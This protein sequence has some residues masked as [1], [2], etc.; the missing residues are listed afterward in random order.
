MKIIFYSHTGKV[1]GAENI[2]LLLLKR[3][4]R[5][6][7]SP[8]MI[9]PATGDLAE[10]VPKLDIPVV[11]VDELT[12]RF[13]W[14]IDRL[15]KY[16]TSFYL[17][18]RQLRSE[19]INEDA[20]V[21]HA[22]SVRAGLAIWAASLFTGKKVFWHLQDELPKHPF[23]TAIRLLVAS[24]SRIRLIAVS[25]AT[26]ESFR[27][28]LLHYIGKNVPLKV[29]NNAIEIEKFKIDPKNRSNVREELN[30][31]ENEFV[32]GIIGQITPRKGQLE[33]IETFAENQKNLPDSTLLIVGAPMF[34]QDHDYLEKIKRTIKKLK[35]ERKVKFLGLRN[36][37][38]AVMQAIDALVVN[39][40]SEAL[41]VVAIEAMACGTPVIATDVGG[42][43]EIIE[44]NVNG[45][46]VPFGDKEKLSDRWQVRCRTGNPPDFCNKRSANVVKH[47][48]AEKFIREIE[49]FFR[50]EIS[51][52]KSVKYSGSA[53][54]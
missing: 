48:N 32:F 44:N 4:N 52:K 28:K 29:I 6:N 47:F 51:D 27:G 35:I 31:S 54:N 43:S 33:L 16:L 49:D 24:S 22:N 18:I 12:A 14:R 3:L 20:D 21:I 1:S 19:I 25:Q 26:A 46:L 8:K 30:L 37:I 53:E 42:T 36:D 17:V 34:N 10:K 23:S 45:W 13:T 15:A 40:K 7:F 41:V 39:S 2:L 9:C 38:S 11:K 50:H 5:T